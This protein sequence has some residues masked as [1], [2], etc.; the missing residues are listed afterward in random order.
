MAA[1]R[2]SSKQHIWIV[3]VVSIAIVVLIVGA[4]CWGAWVYGQIDQF[5]GRDQAGPADAIA[6]FGAA[7]YDGR[8]S[9]VFRARLDH[10]AALYNR[11]IAPLIVALGG[12]GGD[13]FSEGG[14]GREYLMSVGIP[15]SAII[16]ETESRSTA[17]AA[18]RLAAI[19]RTNRFRRLVVVS[20]DTHLFRIH[21]ICAANGLDV[22]TSPR[23][24]VIVEGGNSDLESILHEILSYTAWRLHIE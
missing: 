1:A 21:A 8:P 18:R 22:L 20:D 15:E 2:S 4:L 16:A 12:D 14:V 7:E 19:A 23:P 24:R 9:P 3:R 11:G 17:E 10:A 5:A 6:V 13:Q